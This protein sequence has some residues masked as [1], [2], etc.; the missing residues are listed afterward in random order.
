M[1]APLGEKASPLEKD[2]A[3]GV[4]KDWSLCPLELLQA[5]LELLHAPLQCTAA[6]LGSTGTSNVSNLELF[7]AIFSEKCENMLFLS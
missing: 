6:D 2:E 1:V 5:L 4:S 3:S 7:Q